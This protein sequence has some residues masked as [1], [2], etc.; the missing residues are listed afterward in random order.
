MARAPSGVRA[1]LKK[2]LVRGR[3]ENSRLDR[4]DKWNVGL[5]V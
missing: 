4:L 1:I 3:K 5:A 2:Q